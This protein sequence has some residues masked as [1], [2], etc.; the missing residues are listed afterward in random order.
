VVSREERGISPAELAEV[1]NVRERTLL[2]I[3]RNLY[4][5]SLRL[6]FLASEYLGE[7]V[8]E[9]FWVGQA[10]LPPRS[11]PAGREAGGE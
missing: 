8:E 6:A 7:R 3:E 4:T 2:L 1:L 10:P 9:V 11:G 5:P